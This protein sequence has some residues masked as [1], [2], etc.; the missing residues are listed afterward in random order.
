MDELGTTIS[1][2]KAGKAIGLDSILNEVIKLLESETKEYVISFVNT[3]IRD[4]VMPSE[5]KKGRV[6]LISKN[7]D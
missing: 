5:L 1:E 3:C 4:Q 6:T 7:E 2:L